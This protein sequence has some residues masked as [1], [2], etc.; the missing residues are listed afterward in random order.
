MGRYGVTRPRNFL[1]SAPTPVGARTR[2]SESGSVV[3]SENPID[4]YQVDLGVS[5][6]LD[7]WGKLRR[8]TEAARADLLATEKP[9][10]R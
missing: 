6:E 10:A 4:S 1:R 7:L 9:G 5:F 2:N 8:A 3:L